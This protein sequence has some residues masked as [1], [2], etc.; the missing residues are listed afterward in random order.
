MDKQSIKF[1]TDHLASARS[2]LQSGKFKQAIEYC[3]SVKN[4]SQ[5]KLPI[6]LLL[7]QAYQANSQFDE[8]LSQARTLAKNN[9][10][11]V[12]IKIRLAECLIYCGE[13][14]E[15]IDCLNELASDAQNNHQLLTKLAELLL[16]AAQ[17]DGVLDCHIKA[18][19]LAPNNPQYQYNLASSYLFFGELD[20]AESLLRKIVKQF[21]K[22]YDAFYA[23]STLR[24]QQVDNNN[25]ALLEQTYRKQND[26]AR[27]R[28]TLGYSLAKEYEDTGEYQKSFN[29]LANAAATR[30]Q[31]LSYQVKNDVDALTKISQVFNQEHLDQTPVSSSTESPIFILGLPRSGTT[32]VERILSS[33][34]QVG[35]LGEINN[36]AFSII[37]GVGP[38]QGKLDL[39]EQSIKLNMDQ[40]AKRYTHATRGYGLTQSLLIDK[41]PLNFLYL[42]LIKKAYPK[43]KII[44][45][46]RSPMDSC[47]AMFKTL[48]RMGY[49]FSYDLND[50]AEYYIAYHHLMQH[51]RLI[52]PNGFYELNYQDLVLEPQQQANKLAEYCDLAWEPAMLEFSSNKTASATASAAQVRDGIYKTSVSRWKSYAQ[53]LAP[54][55]EKLQSAGITID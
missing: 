51:W 22:D 38:H 8:M 49:P 41:T 16:H 20:K 24:K 7:N 9:P 32:L 11:Q 10:Q 12:V 44:H 1:K 31:Q 46:Y 45:L 25:I 23:L 15:A 54:L 6:E 4:D 39:I 35:S 27:A 53:Q 40:L 55:A 21:P 36:L 26:Q 2:L 48:F 34:S 17:F 13:M 47:Y 52:F 37:H 18:L 14:Q 30:R 19:N 5:Q 50:L 42:G 33:H 29:F 3:L 28:I 43:A